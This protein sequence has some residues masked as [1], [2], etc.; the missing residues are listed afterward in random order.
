MWVEHRGDCFECKPKQE[1][2]EE[3]EEEQEE[4]QEQGA[5]GASDGLFRFF[6]KSV[7][8]IFTTETL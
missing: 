8:H 7:F 6:S 3:E 5:V 1:E 2:E 4:E